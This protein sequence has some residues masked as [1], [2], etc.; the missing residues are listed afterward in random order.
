MCFTTPGV[1]LLTKWNWDG[2]SIVH[3][4]VV[5]SARPV[6]G[7]RS[8]RNEYAID[9]REFLVTEKNALMRRTL[10]EDM[11]RF[12]QQVG[13]DWDLFNS[14]KA[15][16]FDYRA[17]M[18]T[19]FVACE[20][21]YQPRRGRDPWQF[22]DETL[23]VKRGDCEDRAFLI[24]SLLLA[25]GVSG[26]NVRVALGR[27]DVSQGRRIQKHD[28]AWVM[29]KAE[30]GAWILIEPLKISPG[31]TKAVSKGRTAPPFQGRVEY[32]PQFL[33]NSDHLWCIER[34]VTARVDFRSFLEKKWRRMDPK[35]A[36]QVHQSI[37]TQA[38]TQGG[39]PQW[40]TDAVDSHFHGIGSLTVEDIDLPQWYDSRDHFDNGYIPE[41]WA[42]VTDR[43]SK[44]SAQNTDVVQFARA[45]HGIA[46]FY[47][48][49]SYLHFA[50][51]LKAA[52][53]GG[54]AVP[55]DPANPLAGLVCP[56]SYDA[57]PA[58]ASIPPFDL[59]SANFSLNQNLWK[60]TKADAAAQWK[61][62]IISGR[63]A[64][65][66]DSKSTF[67][68]ITFIPKEL[69]DAPDFANRGALPHHEEIAVDEDGAKRHNQL[70]QA[71][72]PDGDLANR[73]YFANQFRWRKNTA[74]EHI[75]QAFTKNWHQ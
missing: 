13:G 35:F 44:F 57:N 2:D 21:A 41:G 11:C 20:I 42:W 73:R 47:A 10:N 40:F 63:Y 46:D 50:K 70:Y 24:A 71:V 56:P 14:R 16:S 51:L 64:Q 72:G 32:V 4:C 62:K 30:S 7:I 19:A 6:V 28:H 36:G 60:R 8:P 23:F 33:F 54:R 5:P 37:V 22:P 1:T 34:G 52:D 39:A 3:D 31:K 38:L 26:Y 68:A 65:R 48:H 61:G 9:V 58:N 15:S 12:I 17:A 67:E 75:R 53:A 25:S 55:Y 45:A 27:V 43:L 74:I 49:S 18:V 59:T 29:Y 66:K 69:E